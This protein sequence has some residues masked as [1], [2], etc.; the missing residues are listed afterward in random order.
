MDSIE[1][2]GQSL[3]GVDLK[4]KNVIV[5]YILKLAK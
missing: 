1:N 4:Y 3:E 2:A 5:G